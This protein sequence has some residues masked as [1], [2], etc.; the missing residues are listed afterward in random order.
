M[1]AERTLARIL[2]ETGARIY[3]CVP[4]AYIN[5][6]PAPPGWIRYRNLGRRLPSPFGTA[7]NLRLTYSLL[8]PLAGMARHPHA[9]TSSATVITR[10]RRI[11]AQSIVHS[12]AAA[13]PR[14]T[15]RGLASKRPRL[16]LTHASGGALLSC[17]AQWAC[18]AN[19]LELTLRRHR[20]HRWR[21][22]PFFQSPRRSARRRPPYPNRLPRRQG[23]WRCVQW[24]W[25]KVSQEKK[26]SILVNL[27]YRFPNIEI[28]VT[29]LNDIIDN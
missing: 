22:S 9:A 2:R 21:P 5:L 15:P 19:L 16:A 12:L 27:S 8:A 29:V 3:I 18:S 13:K 14:A 25:K 26:C 24:R 11:E 6:D 7:H 1:P 10:R 4:L 23:I 28:S 17:T 20:P